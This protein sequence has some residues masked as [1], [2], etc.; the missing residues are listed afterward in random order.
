MSKG[1]ERRIAGRKGNARQLTADDYGSTGECGL[2]DTFLRLNEYQTFETFFCNDYF[3]SDVFYGA[4]GEPPQPRESGFTVDGENAYFTYAAGTLNEDANGFPELEFTY[5]QGPLTG[6]TTI[7]D[8]EPIVF[9]SVAT[10]PPTNASCNTFVD[11]GVKD[12][13]TITQDHDGHLVTIADEFVSTDR[14]AHEIESLPDNQQNFGEH[15]D[16][17]EYEF[18]GDGGY[19]A[20]TEGESVAFSDSA[21]AAINVRVVGAEDGEPGTGRGAILFYQPSSP[22]YFQLHRRGRAGQLLPRQSRPGSRQRKRGREIR[23]RLGEHRSRSRLAGRYGPRQRSVDRTRFRHGR[24]QRRVTDGGKLVDERDAAQ[25]GAEEDP[26][27]ASEGHPRAPKA[28][29][30]R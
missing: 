2:S 24:G 23:L 18:P 28:P 1:S 17:L 20:Y 3:E 19:A 6:D 12:E 26:D 9:C 8:D 14:S 13:R 25:P 16:E 10:F 5:S 4:D 27:E 21:P 30:S 15:A 29:P 11:S 22:A 7:H